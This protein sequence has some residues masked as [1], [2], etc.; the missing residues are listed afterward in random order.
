MKNIRYIIKSIYFNII[1][2]INRTVEY[3]T[4]ATVAWKRGA[5]LHVAWCGNSKAI[6]GG[7]AKEDDTKSL[8]VQVL[9]PSH[10]IEEANE[11]SKKLDFFYH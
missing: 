6:I 2:I 4:T 8:E 7:L 11:R 10:T 5:F 1:G 3:G 9:T